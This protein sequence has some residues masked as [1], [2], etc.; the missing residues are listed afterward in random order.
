MQV[1]CMPGKKGLKQS[2]QEQLI[3]A[4][5]DAAAVLALWTKMILRLQRLTTVAEAA[6]GTFWNLD[7]AGVVEQFQVMGIICS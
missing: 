2:D 6:V 1:S 3:A 5:H 7:Y 4:S